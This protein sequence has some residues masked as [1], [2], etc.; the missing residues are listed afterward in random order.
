V[1]FHI[2]FSFRDGTFMVMK[3]CCRVVSVLLSVGKRFFVFEGAVC[4][5]KRLLYSSPDTAVSGNKSFLEILKN[6]FFKKG[7]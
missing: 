1:I 2:A 7:S 5:S 3:G 6:L 4:S